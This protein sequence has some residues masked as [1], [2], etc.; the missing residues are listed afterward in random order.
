MKRH[1]KILGALVITMIITTLS[2]INVFA[3]TAPPSI[4]GDSITVMDAKTGAVVYE[5]NKDVQY[6]PAS[7]T[8]LMTILLTLENT[9]LSEVVT[10]GELP[11]TIEGSKIYIGTGEQLTVEEMLKA[12]IMVSAN[13]CATALAEHISGS[14][15]EFSKLMNKRAKELGC[16][17]TNFTNPHG[18]Y[19]EHHRTTSYDLAL[20]EKE[21]LKFPEYLQISKI[22]AAFIDPTNIF[23]ERRPLWNDNRLIQ[24]YDDAY[25]EYALAGKTGYT[26]ESL[27]SYVASA[28]KDGMTFV[29]SILHDKYKA[30]YNEVGGVFD[31][32]FE[33]FKTEKLCSKGDILDNYT[34]PN[35][36]VI[37]L[38]ASKD[39]YYTKDITSKEEPVLKVNTDVLNSIFFNKDETITTASATYGNQTYSIDVL[40]GCDYHEE[41][42]PIFGTSL[43]TSDN[44]INYK[45]L[46]GI[47]VLSIGLILITIFII[48]RIIGK[49]IMRKRRRNIFSSKKR[50][51]F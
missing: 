9:D 31:W 25:Y 26:D 18:L 12:V 48:L 46:A 14:V 23:E 47:I 22:Q 17:N 15:E 34:A 45:K 50:R 44:T 7:T 43:T 51:R 2:S 21:L 39:I 3:A 35:G 8:K 5:K 16:L 49:I 24:P 27:H 13:D 20:I 11:P 41:E 4:T 36:T 37:P 10:V 28:E 32:A 19:G 6:P 40:S 33:N 30:Y 1:I 42:I 38:I 29:V